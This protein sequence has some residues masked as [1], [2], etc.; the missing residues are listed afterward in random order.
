MQNKFSG[1][2]NVSHAPLCARLCNGW[3]QCLNWPNWRGARCFGDTGE[4]LLPM[5]RKFVFVPP[6]HI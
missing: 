5:L 2:G 4:C 6:P 3:D 1:I